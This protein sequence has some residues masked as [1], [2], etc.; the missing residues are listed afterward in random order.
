MQLTNTTS[1]RNWTKWKTA[2]VIYVISLVVYIITCVC[3]GSTEMRIEI[4]TLIFSIVPVYIV[5][6]WSLDEA[7][8]GT[9]EQIEILQKLTSEQISA[10][11]E[12]TQLQVEAFATQSEGIVSA[13]EK[14]VGAVGQMSEDVRKQVEQEEK[15]LA[16]TQKQN[17]D[18]LRAL[19]REA[20]R[21]WEKK[22]RIAPR[23]FARIASES[24]LFFFRHYRLYVYN[25]GGPAKNMKLDY[26]FSNSY[27]TVKKT[28][29]IGS[30]DRDRG[31]RSIDC[32][33]INALTAYPVIQV[34]VYLR[35]QEERL[36]VGAIT[37]D[38]SNPEWVQIPL[39]ERPRE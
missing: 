5:L 14:V 37:I 27:N 10:L 29:S 1:G 13:I 7:R 4:G 32:G 38:K 18:R 23:I 19:E 35:D 6:F 22:E 20:Q 8:R 26:F 31:S 16:I 15:R 39:E 17:E 30:L 21:D 33:D 28:V 11:K 36:Y 25:A 34:S 3:Y 24:F 12:S 2:S 9:Y